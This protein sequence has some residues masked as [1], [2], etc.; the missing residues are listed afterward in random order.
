MFTHVC[1]IFANV[2]WIHL[3]EVRQLTSDD[4]QLT[5]AVE[6]QYSR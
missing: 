1:A 5:S 6:S 4:R 3:I 2:K